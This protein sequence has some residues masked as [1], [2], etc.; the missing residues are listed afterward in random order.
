MF[1]LVVPQSV[2]VQMVL[3]VSGTSGDGLVR[4]FASDYPTLLREALGRMRRGGPEVGR[5]HDI[6]GVEVYTHHLWLPR[7]P[8][9]HLFL[10]RI[11]DGD[12]VEVGHLLHEEMPLH[13]YI[14]LQWRRDARKSNAAQY[15]H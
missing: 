1:R 9:Y 8:A 5:W 6:N 12:V 4:A 7:V 10:Y 14:P 13:L 15:S 2:E 11:V 3:T